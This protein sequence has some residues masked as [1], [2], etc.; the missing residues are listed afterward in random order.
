MKKLLIVALIVIV[1]AGSAVSAY[2]YMRTPVEPTVS[3]VA[4]SLGDVIQLVAA[5]G[6]LEAVTTVDVGT[7]VN[8]VI[9]EMYADFNSIVKK[10]QLV[11]KIDPTTI[12]AAI[13]SDRAN[14]EGAQATLERLAIG[15]EDSNEQTETRGRPVRAKAD[16]AAGPGNRAGER[17]DQRSVDQVAGGEH[18]AVAGEVGPGPREPGLHEHPRAD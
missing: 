9:K 11:A 18:Q 13:E 1:V 10:G 8:G 14:L 4:V 12:E 2:V 6:T 17:Q 5:T 15:L 7:Q 3:T 16:H